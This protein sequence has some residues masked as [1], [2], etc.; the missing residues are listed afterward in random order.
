[1]RIAADITSAIF[2]DIHDRDKQVATKQNDTRCEG[3]NWYCRRFGV[4]DHVENC[5]VQNSIRLIFVRRVGLFE[6]ETHRL[7]TVNEFG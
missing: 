1:L 6:V 5:S 4:H 2:H 3:G 7:I